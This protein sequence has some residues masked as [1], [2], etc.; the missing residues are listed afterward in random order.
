MG[1]IL[2][3]V[4]LASTPVGLVVTVVAAVG[5]FYFMRWVLAD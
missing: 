5:A 3:L 1:A 4:N 2:E